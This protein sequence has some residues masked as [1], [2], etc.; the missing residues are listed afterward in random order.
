MPRDKK[1]HRFQSDNRGRSIKIENS[2]NIFWNHTVIYR[3]GAIVPR[4]Y[5]T[6]QELSLD[7][8]FNVGMMND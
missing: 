2:C 7:N 6:G 8:V 3:D 1:Y 5:H 4:D